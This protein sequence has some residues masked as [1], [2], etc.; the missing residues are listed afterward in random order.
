MVRPLLEAGA[1][2]NATDLEGYTP[3]HIAVRDNYLPVINLLLDNGADVNAVTSDGKTI[4]DM[5]VF[6]GNER[7]IELFGG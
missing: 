5:A 1:D 4:L 2:V 3:L 6:S 7:V